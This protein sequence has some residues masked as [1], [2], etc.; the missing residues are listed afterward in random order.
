MCWQPLSLKDPTSQELLDAVEQESSYRLI[1]PSAFQRNSMDE[2]G[3][4]QVPAYPDDS[5]FEE[6]IMQHLAAAARAH[7]FAR[8]DTLRNRPMSVQDHP[9]LVMVPTRPP[10]SEVPVVTGRATMSGNFTPL[11][12]VGPARVQPQEQLVQHGG[13]IDAA[14]LHTTRS[15][16]DPGRATEINRMETYSA[17]HERHNIGLEHVEENQQRSAP[18]EQLSFSDTLK[19]RLAAASSRYKETF[20]KTTRGFRERLRARNNAM[21]D[22][23]ARAREVSAGVVRALERISLESSGKNR[24]ENDVPTTSTDTTHL[25]E[26]ASPTEAENSGKREATME[27]GCSTES[28]EAPLHGAD[29]SRS[30]LQPP[31]GSGGSFNES[32]KDIEGSTGGEEA[33]VTTAVAAS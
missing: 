1:R 19:S 9:P 6:Q 26:L 13:L 21:T 25:N 23:G 3:L 15:V 33:H 10:S 27:I 17:R 14:A 24:G 2:F 22:L 8:R 11:S 7:H 29:V 28:S 18:S 31:S 12:A 16:V 32:S 5:D 4:H 30:T 20:S